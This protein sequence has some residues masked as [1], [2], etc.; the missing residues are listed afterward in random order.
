M[1][2]KAKKQDVLAYFNGRKEKEIVIDPAKI[3]SVKTHPVKPSSDDDG[4]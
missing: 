2:G 4:E 3:R 1:E